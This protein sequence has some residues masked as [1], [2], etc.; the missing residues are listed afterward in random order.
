MRNNE[1]HTSGGIG[2]LRAANDCLHH[3]KANARHQL[4]LALGAVA[5]LDWVLHIICNYRDYAVHYMD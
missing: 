2:F 1:K 4:E 3:P 5:N